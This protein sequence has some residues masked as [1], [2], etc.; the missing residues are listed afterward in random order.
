MGTMKKNLIKAGIGIIL[1]LQISGLQAGALVQGNPVSANPIKNLHLSDEPIPLQLAYNDS[2]DDNAPAP[3]RRKAQPADQDDQDQQPAARP[4]ARTYN[5]A[6]DDQDQQPAPR[7][8]AR[9]PRRVHQVNVPLVVVG[10]VC[11][12]AGIGLMIWGFL[13]NEQAQGSTT[14][15]YSGSYS[16]NEWYYDISGTYTNSGG[17]G[18]YPT[19]NLY[20]ADGNYWTNALIDVPPGGTQD[21]YNKGWDDYNFSNHETTWTATTTQIWDGNYYINSGVGVFVGII[22]VAAGATM[23]ILGFSHTTEALS[24]NGVDVHL[25]TA[26][27][28]GTV[29]PQNLRLACTKTF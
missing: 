3:A 7:R 19:V 16:S 28:S 13:P 15:S 23:M 24:D 18:V 20:A 4:A 11:L 21:W 6:D 26:D 17:A 12:V 25:M 29:N 9:R 14:M 8:R 22:A 5:A 2:D 10:G 27:N 1:V